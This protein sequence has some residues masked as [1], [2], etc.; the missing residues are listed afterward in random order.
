MFGWA[1]EP[2]FYSLKNMDIQTLLEKTLPGMGYELVDVELFSG[3]GIRVFIDKQPEGINVDDCAVVSNHLSRL[4]MVESIDYSRLEVSSPGLDR[5]L[6]SEADLIRFTGSL[7]KIRTKLPIDG[8]KRFIGRLSGIEEGSLLI[9]ME[10][11]NVNIPLSCIEKAR[12]E[13][14]F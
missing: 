5:K 9:E 6:K 2:I 10:G 3:N 11:K 4:F 7:A 12:L 14:E 13:P 1:Q 8:Q